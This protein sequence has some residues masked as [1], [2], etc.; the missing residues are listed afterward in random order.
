M[1]PIL[2]FL[3]W[4]H[5]PVIV[6]G[7]ESRCVYGLMCLGVIVECFRWMSEVWQPMAHGERG[8]ECTAAVGG[9]ALASTPAPSAI[10]SLL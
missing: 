4:L 8:D 5:S 6:D 9:L 2:D 3:V 10:C 7:G 1:R